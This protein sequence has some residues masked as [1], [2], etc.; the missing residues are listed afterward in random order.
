MVTRD[1]SI[2]VPVLGARRSSHTHP[3][4]P[5]RAPSPA[6]GL[7]SARGQRCQGLARRRDYH[8]A[9]PP[10]AGGWAPRGERS[11]R[12]DRGEWNGGSFPPMFA[13][14]PLRTRSPLR[15]HPTD[16]F[17]TGPPNR[18]RTKIPWECKSYRTYMDGSSMDE[19]NMVN[20]C[21]VCS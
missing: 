6:G 2:P 4:I 7:S 21:P 5:A 19:V 18:Q 11:G 8:R 9:L 15:E 3:P 1:P 16:G 12:G 13:S 20:P 14:S 17:S 10:A